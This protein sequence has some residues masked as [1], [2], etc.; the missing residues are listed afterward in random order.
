LGSKS[1]RRGTHLGAREAATA[2]G[3]SGRR[4]GATRDDSGPIVSTRKRGRG[5]EAAGEH[6]HHNAKLLECLLDGG[7]RQ[8][9]EWPKHG[10]NGGGGRARALRVSQEGG[11]CGLGEKLGHGG[12]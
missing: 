2:A 5:R 7:E 4:R 11:G 12:L 6:P 9:S 10:G 1:A 3:D 8:H